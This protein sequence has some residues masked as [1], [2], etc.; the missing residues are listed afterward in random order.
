MLRIVEVDAEVETENARSLDEIARAGAQRMLKAALL[1]EVAHY[2]DAHKEE[3]DERGRRL[4]TRNG[5]ARERKIATGTG[6]LKVRVPRVRD[7]GTDEQ[8]RRRSFSSKI[9]PPH[10]RRSPKVAEVIPI[11]YLRGLSTGDF[12]PALSALLGE[13][14]AGLSPTTITQLTNDWRK[15][16]EQFCNRDL[17]D[18]EY[19]YVWADGIHFRVRLEEDRLCTLVLMGVRADGTKELIAVTD[20]YRESAESWSELL[21]DLR[22][23]GMNAPALA[24]GDGAQGFR[25]AVRKVWPETRDQ[26]CWVHKLANVLDKLPKCVQPRAKKALHQ[27]MD[28]ESK[29]DALAAAK[30]FEEEFDAKYPKAVTCLTNDLDTL[31]SFYDFQQYTGGSSAAPTRSRVTLRHRQAA[32]ACGERSAVYRGTARL[33]PVD[34]VFVL[35]VPASG[36]SLTPL[37]PLRDTHTSNVVD[38]NRLIPLLNRNKRKG[39]NV[40]LNES[41]DMSDLA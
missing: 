21:R 5:L 15:E 34:V 38:N 36:D 14:G 29:K 19:V 31:L 27:I 32:T 13:D 40:D 17:S 3:R 23:R 20:G 35:P 7:R 33:M 41:R 4:I 37:K 1:A 10:M 22:R 25:A 39:L 26:R 16:Y 28:A 12:K 8:G 9:L 11:L 18:Q 30:E 24:I 6:T 2:I